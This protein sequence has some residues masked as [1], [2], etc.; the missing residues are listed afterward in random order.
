MVQLTTY[1]LDEQTTI[2]LWNLSTTAQYGATGDD[3]RLVQYLLARAPEAA[4]YEP[5]KISGQSGITVDDVDGIW[6]PQ[7]AAAQS[8]LE[9]NWAGNL[10]VAADGRVDPTFVDSIKFG[11]NDAY[12]FKIAVLQHL[13]A[14]AQLQ[15]RV[16]S[17]DT[18]AMATL[19]ENMPND[20]Q[21]P[22]DLAYALQAVLAS[23][24]GDSQS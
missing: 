14:V 12:E 21:C 8:W 22:P 17:A 1:V 23:S 15:R 16:T 19:G 7:T 4:A 3:V 2:R 24:G 13:Y 11:P 20:G 9:Q 10:K 18:E 6:G 5:D